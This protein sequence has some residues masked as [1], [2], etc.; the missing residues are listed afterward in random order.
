VVGESNVQQVAGVFQSNAAAERAVAALTSDLRRRCLRE[1]FIWYSNGRVSE[2]KGQLPGG[3]PRIE[4]DW[5]LISFEMKQ[6][7]A[8]PSHV[9][10]ALVREGRGLTETLYLTEQ[11]DSP[12]RLMEDLA[13]SSDEALAKVPS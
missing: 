10:I 11:A 4:G 7:G 13:S 8:P 2:G 6:D 3:D 9:D 5:S 1:T 12:Y